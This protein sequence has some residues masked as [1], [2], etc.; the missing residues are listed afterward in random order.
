[1]IGPDRTLTT[2]SGVTN[3]Y[4]VAAG[5][6][7][8]SVPMIVDDGRKTVLFPTAESDAFG[9]SMGTGYIS[10]DTLINGEGYWLKFGSAQNVSITGIPLSLDTIDV[11]MGWNLVG[12]I[13]EVIDASTIVQIPA[14]I[15]QLPFYEYN[16]SYNTS[17]TLAPARAYWVRSSASGRLVL[18]TGSGRPAEATKRTSERRFK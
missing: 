8:I 15:L 17:E 2:P 4:S 6:G 12:S 13:T 18:S 10:K 1:M 9:F 7:L 11:T 16:G 3:Q 5:W 14:G